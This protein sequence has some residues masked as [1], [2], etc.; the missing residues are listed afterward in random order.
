[1][2]TIQDVWQRKATATSVLNR[3]IKAEILRQKAIDTG[4]MKNVSRIVQLDWNEV[5]DDV[6]LK[7]D[8][9]EYYKYVDE[10]LS[11]KWHNRSIPRNITKAFMKREKVVDQLDKLITVIFEYRIDQ[12]FKTWQ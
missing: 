1:M 12:Q 6:S 9:T 2:A 3:E 4:R 7:I 10:G 8:S 11:R 5:T